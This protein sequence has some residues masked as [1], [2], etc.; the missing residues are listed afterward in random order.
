MPKHKGEIMGFDFEHMIVLIYTGD[1]TETIAVPIT[2]E[3]RRSLVLCWQGTEGRLL[4][5]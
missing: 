5:Q 4:L 3:Q 1:G 2:E